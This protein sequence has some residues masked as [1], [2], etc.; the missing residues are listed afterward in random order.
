MQGRPFSTASE[1]RERRS[2]KGFSEPQS[3][4]ELPSH[5]LLVAT[6]LILSGDELAANVG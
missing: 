1:K 4:T 5:P 2:T 3:P 6:A